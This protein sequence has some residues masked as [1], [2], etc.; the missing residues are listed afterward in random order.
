M[1]ETISHA[2]PFFS[3]SE[4]GGTRGGCDFLLFDLLCR[5]ER[6]VGSFSAFRKLLRTCVPEI[7]SIPQRTG[8]GL[9]F[10]L[11][12]DCLI[13]TWWRYERGG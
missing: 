3:L 2:S 7:D 12:I 6:R 5:E 8:I 9:E 13:E 10:D 11:L 4:V 1:R